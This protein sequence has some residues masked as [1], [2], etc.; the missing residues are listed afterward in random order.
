MDNIVDLIATDASASDITD[1]IK[2]ALY[3]KAS[4]RVEG[5]RPQVASSI[6]SE[7]EIEDEPTIEPEEESTEND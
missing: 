3:G 2:D 5:I 1:K 7:P 4:E 6:F